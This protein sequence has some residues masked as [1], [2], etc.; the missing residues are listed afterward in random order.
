[1][2]SISISERRFRSSFAIHAVSLDNGS[3]WQYEKRIISYHSKI[4]AFEASITRMERNVSDTHGKAII[5]L[6][7]TVTSSIIQERHRD[8]FAE[9]NYLLFYIFV[10]CPNSALG[11]LSVRSRIFIGLVRIIF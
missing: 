6:S 4:V 10:K 7:F 3:I 9:C 8:T 2:V 11:P 5:S 1:M